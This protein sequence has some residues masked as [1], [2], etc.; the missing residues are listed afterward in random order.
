[1][2]EASSTPEVSTQVLGQKE[3]SHDAKK[4]AAI[5]KINFINNQR[6]QDGWRVNI[7]DDALK[8]LMVRDVFEMRTLRD[9]IRK[10]GD[11]A[12]GHLGIAPSI[13]RLLMQAR[14]RTIPEL[15]KTIAAQ[16]LD[17]L[18]RMSKSVQGEILTARERLKQLQE[19]K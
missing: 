8:T 16:R 14:I 4:Q 7:T 6:E 12:I 11:D 13:W 1:M 18:P 19:K 17:A 3:N 9:S 10:D 15:D 2:N 5:R